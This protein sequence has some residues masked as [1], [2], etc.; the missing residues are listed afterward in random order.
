[1]FGVDLERDGWL[2]QVLNKRTENTKNCLSLSSMVGLT[3]PEGK[4]CQD[5]R[6]CNIRKHAAHTIQDLMEITEM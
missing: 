6:Q 3:R 1:M 4:L 5:R 2:K